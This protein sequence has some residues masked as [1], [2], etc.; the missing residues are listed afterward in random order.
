MNNK[1]LELVNSSQVPV[2]EFV[3]YTGEYP[4]LCSGDLTIKINGEE[5]TLHRVLRSGGSVWFDD[6]SSE[7]VEDGEWTLFRLPDEIA[8]LHDEILAVVRENIPCG[9]CGGCV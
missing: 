8:H 5:I 6:D 2:V 1:P 3:S 9:C 4:N 7:H